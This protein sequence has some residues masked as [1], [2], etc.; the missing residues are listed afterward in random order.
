MLRFVACGD[1]YFAIFGA[2]YV[3]SANPGH[4]P[5]LLPDLFACARIRPVLPQVESH[6]YLTQEALRRGIGY[7]IS[8]MR[9]R[10]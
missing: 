4:A 8:A 2:T 3:N 5:G 9:E 10:T 1:C 6:P 7:S